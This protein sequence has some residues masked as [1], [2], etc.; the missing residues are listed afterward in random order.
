[1]SITPKSRPQLTQDRAIAHLVA[2][3]V[4]DRDPIALLGIR[5][6]YRDTMGKPGVP[7]RAPHGRDGRPERHRANG[8]NRNRCGGDTQSR[9]LRTASTEGFSHAA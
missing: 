6:Y 7:S 4:T 1:M 5:G 8:R 2:A 3:G 9:A